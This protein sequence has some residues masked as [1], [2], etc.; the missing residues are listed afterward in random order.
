MDRQVLI[1]AAHRNIGCFGAL[2]LKNRVIG[3]LQILRCAAPLNT[4]LYIRYLF[5]YCHDYQSPNFPTFA[6]C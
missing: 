4:L 1:G 3:I 6:P 2:H 5:N